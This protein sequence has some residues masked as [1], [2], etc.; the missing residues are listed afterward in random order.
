MSFWKNKNFRKLKNT[1]IVLVLHLKND[2]ALS[3]PG[4]N[5]RDP[6]AKLKYT[7]PLM[8]NLYMPTKSIMHRMCVCML[9]LQSG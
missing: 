3:H 1:T 7:Q 2:K 6:C 9:T 8:Y 5:F 4:V